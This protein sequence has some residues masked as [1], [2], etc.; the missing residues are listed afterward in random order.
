LVHIQLAFEWIKDKP[1]TVGMLEQLQKMV[2]RGT[3]GDSHDA[4]RIRTTQV[5]IG[6]DGGRVD[7]ARFV[8]SPP[9]T[10]YVSASTPGR[11]GSWPKIR[12]LW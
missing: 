8:P 10:S 7:D 3:R 6:A 12:S 2:V 4:G 1:I 9:V 11:R 5:F